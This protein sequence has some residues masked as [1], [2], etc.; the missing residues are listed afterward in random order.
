MK[1]KN[2]TF[3]VKISREKVRKVSK[4]YKEPNNIYNCIC[5]AFLFDQAPC[6]PLYSCYN[7]LTSKVIVIL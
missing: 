7:S 2:R 5:R 3:C 6:F 4:P 1:Q